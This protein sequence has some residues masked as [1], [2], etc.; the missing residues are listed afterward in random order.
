[1]KLDVITFGSA[2]RDIF[3]KPKKVSLLKYDASAREGV[4]F[5]LGSKIDIEEL[6]FTTGGGGTNS[7][8][9]FANQGFKTAYCGAIGADQ[10]GKDIMA[11]LQTLKIANFV[12]W[13]KEKATNHSVI[14]TNSGHDRTILAY[15]GASELLDYRDIPW[16]KLKAAW[17]YIAPLTGL[18]AENFHKLVSVAKKNNIKVAVNPSI[19][20]LSLPNFIHIAQKVD[21]LIL[22][23]EEAS[24]LT[25][26]SFERE[27]E[28]F[29]KID[30]LCPGIAIMTKG[31][32]GVVV[33]DGKHLYSA[34]PHKEPNIQDTTGAGDAFGSGFV[35]EFMRSSDIGKAIQF[36]MANSTGCISEMGA[37]NGLL[38]KGQKFERVE[39]IKEEI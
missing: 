6:Y 31:E 11:E 20:Q 26:I 13:K 36:A 37:K 25:K 24:F 38:K 4:C 32:E 3:L 17:F 27:Q 23:Q 28:I 5:P 18:L 8:A 12:A 7:A 9:T 2:T 21:V 1:M 29:Q 19:A 22:N 14:I 34:K 30:E 16:S 35:A 33:S 39:V 10:A 15:R